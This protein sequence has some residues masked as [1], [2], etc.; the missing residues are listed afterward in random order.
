MGTAKPKSNNVTGPGRPRLHSSD[1][2]R[3]AAFRSTKVRKELLL[4]QA[5]ADAIAYISS[6]LDCSQQELLL[7]LVRFA[8]TNRNWR[9]VGLYGG[10]EDVDRV[11]TGVHKRSGNT[12]AA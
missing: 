8:L 7:S 6:D 1:G 3:V 11:R 2:A 5:T 4:P 10:R 9:V 12:P